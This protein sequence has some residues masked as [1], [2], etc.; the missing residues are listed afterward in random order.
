MRARQLTF[1]KRTLSAMRRA[2]T[3]NI[4]R[5]WGERRKAMAE[6]IRGEGAHPVGSRKRIVGRNLLRVA[7][8]EAIYEFTAATYGVSARDSELTFSAE[9]AWANTSSVSLGVAGA[10]AAIIPPSWK[11]TAAGII[12]PVELALSAVRIAVEQKVW[13]KIGITPDPAGTLLTPF[14][15]GIMEFAYKASVVYP[16]D[17]ESRLMVG[18]V[19][20]YGNL[21]R[22]ANAGIMYFIGKRIGGVKEK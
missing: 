5:E 12:I 6:G 3:P 18:L 19:G 9:R 7:G 13:G 4:I 21:V 1:G 15:A 14:V 22:M 8:A 2:V 11:E 16:Q 20:I 10:V 17:A